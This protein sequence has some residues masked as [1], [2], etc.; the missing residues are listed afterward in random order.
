VCVLYC[1]ANVCVCVWLKLNMWPCVEHNHCI[2]I[3]DDPTIVEI[4]I[5]N[6]VV[7]CV[8]L[9]VVLL[10][11]VLLCVSMWYVYLCDC[12]DDCVCIVCVCGID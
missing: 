2:I 8:M 5:I 4:L 10:I 7:M 9:C 11:D 1:V 3:I 6:V 12:C